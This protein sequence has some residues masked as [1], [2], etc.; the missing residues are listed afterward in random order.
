MKYY[1]LIIVMTMVSSCASLFLK[2]A[3]TNSESFV[4]ILF[5]IHL[6]LGG[7]LYVMAAL[8][9]I[10]VLKFLDY[11]VVMPLTAITY[12][13]TMVLAF[14]ILNEKITRK[15][16]CGVVLIFIGALFVSF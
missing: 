3:S 2:K 9:N 1:M 16:I 7:F 8:I 5:D 14:F 12:V 13:W 10:L 15:Q 11:S 4:K 6:Y